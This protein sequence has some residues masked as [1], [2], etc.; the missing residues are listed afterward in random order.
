MSKPVLPEQKS[1]PK[2][3]MPE[4]KSDPELDS[5]SDPDLGLD[6]RLEEEPELSVRMNFRT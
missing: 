2:P 4:L 3:V 6:V 1:D 5:K